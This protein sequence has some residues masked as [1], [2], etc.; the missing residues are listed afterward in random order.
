VLV[1][2]RFRLLPRFGLLSGERRKLTH[3]RQA[4]SGTTSKRTPQT[5]HPAVAKQ[6]ATAV[7]AAQ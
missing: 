2:T 7:I 4:R 3:D 6:R 5:A 1:A